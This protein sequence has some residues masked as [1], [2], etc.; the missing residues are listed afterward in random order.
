MCGHSQYQLE[1]TDNFALCQSIL[2]PPGRTAWI[3]NEAAYEADIYANNEKFELLPATPEGRKG[4]QKR[5]GKKREEKE[6]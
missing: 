3:V 4:K 6:K 5:R 2:S 1:Y